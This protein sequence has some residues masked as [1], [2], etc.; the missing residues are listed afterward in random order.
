MITWFDMITWYDKYLNILDGYLT[1]ITLPMRVD[2]A[3]TLIF[4]YTIFIPQ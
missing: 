3:F 4:L 2:R 1:Y